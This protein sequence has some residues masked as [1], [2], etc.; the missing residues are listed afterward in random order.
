MT[1]EA[2][3]NE[4]IGCQQQARQCIIQGNYSQAASLYEQA[5]NAEPDVKSHYWHLGLT[6]L[7]Q[8]QEAEAHTTWLLGMVGGDPEEV[9]RWTEEL[10]QVLHTEAERY[11]ALVEHSVVWLI[12][13][14]LREI[15]PADI[16]NLLHLIQLGIQLETFTGD[17]LKD[18]GVIELL[19]VAPPVE[20][21]FGLLMQTLQRVLDYTPLHPLSVELVQAS[22]AHVRDNQAF[23]IAVFPAA[24]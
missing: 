6:L 7:L 5:I 24:M 8:G 16:N 11:S 15:C 22:L 12:R 4:S 20:V 10:R 17:E 9:E 13:Q 23:L 2:A 3:L 14:H 1:Y 19:E 21:D 18:W